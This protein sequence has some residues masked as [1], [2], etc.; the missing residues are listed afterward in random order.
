MSG[1]DSLEIYW[2]ELRMA[3]A[4]LDPLEGVPHGPKTL[5]ESVEPGDLV[6]GTSKNRILVI[7][8]PDGTLVFGPEYRPNKAAEVFWEAM[9]QR[10]EAYEE[11]GLI[12]RHIE[13]ILLQLGQAD[14]LAESYKQAALQDPTLENEQAA[15]GA[16]L[17]LELVMSQA[18]ELGRGLISRPET[19]RPSVPDRIPPSI[20]Q[21]PYSAYQG[22]K[23]LEKP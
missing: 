1:E 17:S 11:R 5:F 18:I 20:E 14:M 19:P 3:R 4:R 10:R 9:A 8:K 2:D 15:T 6:I 12:L 7:I 21:H 16:L 22:L 23:G 13:A